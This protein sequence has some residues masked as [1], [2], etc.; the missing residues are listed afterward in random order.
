MQALVLK[1]DKELEYRTIP[2]PR[3]SSPSDVLVAVKCAGICGSD[4]PRAFRAGP[5]IIHSSWGTSFPES[6]R[7][8]DRARPMRQEI[9][10]RLSPHSLRRL[11]ALPNRRLRPMRAL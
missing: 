1:K 9:A 7:K 10:S 6:S 8:P 2:T 11:R 5:T 4:I 3:P